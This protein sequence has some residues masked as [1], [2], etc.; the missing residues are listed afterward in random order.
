MLANPTWLEVDINPV[1]A[2][3][4]GALAVDALIVADVRQ[5][6]WDFEDPGGADTRA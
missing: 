5:P 6:D 2:S 1:M 3:S 4:T